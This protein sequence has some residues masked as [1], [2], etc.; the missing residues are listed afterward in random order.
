MA[1]NGM[2]SMSMGDM[3]SMSSGGL[4]TATN[5]KLARGYWYAIAAC[6]ALLSL[7]RLMNFLGA[8]WP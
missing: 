6:I 8:R 7:V 4:F 5:S 3:D 2:S 1:M